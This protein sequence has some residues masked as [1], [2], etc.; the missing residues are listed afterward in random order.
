MDGSDAE[1]RESVVLL[2]R[3]FDDDDIMDTRHEFHG[4]P[5]SVD[6]HLLH[7]TRPQFLF[8]HMIGLNFFNSFRVLGCIFLFQEYHF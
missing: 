7:A 5:P 2:S 8:M 3:P 1:G 4:F 6:S